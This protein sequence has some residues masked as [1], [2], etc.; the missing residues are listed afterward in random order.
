MLDTLNILALEAGASC[1]WTALVSLA[2][3]GCRV[4]VH[5]LYSSAT[6]VLLPD[7][8]FLDLFLDHF[9]LQLRDACRR[10]YLD[11]RLQEFAVAFLY[12]TRGKQNIH[13]TFM[14]CIAWMY[15]THL[16]V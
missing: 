10:V 9:S 3:P 6:V 1:L 5:K 16:I 11:S 15:G 2:L 13:K 14:N 4:K 8:L 12:Y 7:F